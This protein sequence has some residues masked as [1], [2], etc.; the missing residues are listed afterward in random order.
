MAFVCPLC[1]HVQESGHECDVCGRR[2]AEVP[3]DGA[4]AA[5]PLEEI[6]PTRAPHADADAPLLTDLEPHGLATAVPEAGREAA[7]SAVCPYCGRPGAPG[8]RFCPT[9][10]VKLPLRIAPAPPEG[11][12][13]GGRCA[14]CGVVVT[15]EVCPAC[16]SRRP[17]S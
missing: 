10:G 16:G 2:P 5:S 13:P 11:A 14:G 7:S 1:E 4:P 17:G 8:E 12:E 6:E 3:E 9:C 15:R